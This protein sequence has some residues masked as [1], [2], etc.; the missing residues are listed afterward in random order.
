MLGFAFILKEGCY[1]YRVLWQDKF[2]QK[3]TDCHPIPN[4][5]SSY[6]ITWTASIYPLGLTQ[7]QLELASRHDTGDSP[8]IKHRN[9]LARAYI[10]WRLSLPSWAVVSAEIPTFMKALKA[11]IT[12]EHGN[13]QPFSSAF[14]G[15]YKLQF[16]FSAKP[17]EYKALH[18]W[19]M[20]APAADWR[21]HLQA[22]G[23]QKAFI[24]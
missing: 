2:G 9:L 11:H 15:N 5:P 1:C 13:S 7:S 18:Q 12:P 3:I 14:A 24:S 10:S 20:F 21:V 22:T 16:G 8:R 19:L 23:A 17:S 6:P 4:N